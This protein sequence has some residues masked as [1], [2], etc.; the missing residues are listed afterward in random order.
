MY[1]VDCH[2]NLL[3]ASLAVWNLRS[4]LDFNTILVT[5]VDQ[6]DGNGENQTQS[7]YSIVSGIIKVGLKRC[8]RLFA[9]TVFTRF[10]HCTE[11]SNPIVKNNPSCTELKNNPVFHKVRNICRLNFAILRKSGKLQYG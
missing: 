7:C 9:A 2:L 11:E 5:L 3:V 10:V 1:E 8:N 4:A 6:S